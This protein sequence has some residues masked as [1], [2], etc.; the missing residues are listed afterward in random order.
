MLNEP[1]FVA[2]PII[3]KK[4]KAGDIVYTK[5]QLDIVNYVGDINYDYGSH[6][7]YHYTKGSDGYDNYYDV[8]YSGPP[9][10]MNPV[11]TK[12][13]SIIPGHELRVDT[14]KQLFFCDQATFFL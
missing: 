14:I 6:N 13:V 4:V 5:G 11:T 2:V 7:T 10:W 12:I 1:P 8:P 9:V 3:P